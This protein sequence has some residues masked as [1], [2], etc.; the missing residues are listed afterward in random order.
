VFTSISS[1]AVAIDISTLPTISIG[2]VAEMYRDHPQ[3][4][5]TATK[6]RQSLET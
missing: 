5:S 4:R 3:H 2:I 6:Q 1:W